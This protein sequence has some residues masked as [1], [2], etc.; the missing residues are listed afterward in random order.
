MILTVIV[1]GSANFL[2]SRPVTAL[3]ILHSVSLM[4]PLLDLV[5]TVVQP[6]MNWSQNTAGED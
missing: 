4:I 3:Q 5:D 1:V 2:S 6:D